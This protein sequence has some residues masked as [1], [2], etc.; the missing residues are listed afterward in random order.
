V[1]RRLVAPLGTIALLIVVVKA[2]LWVG[3]PSLAALRDG[4]ATLDETLGG[5]ATLGAWLLLGWVTLVLVGTALAILPGAVGRAGSRAVSVITPLAARR[6][7]RVALGLAVA[8]GPVALSA[9]PAVASGHGIAGSGPVAT[10][11]VADSP[12]LPLIGRPTRPDQTPQPT[13][14][15]DVASIQDVA[16]DVP[17][18]AGDPSGASV[19][20]TDAAGPGENVTAP[21]GDVTAPSGDVTAPSGDVTAPSGDVTAPSD[22]TSRVTVR[23][24]DTLWAIAARHLG[25]AASDAQIAAE[26][27]RWYEMNRDA[28]GDDPDLILPGTELSP[29]KTP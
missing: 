2:L 7:A 5:V 12:D 22:Q 1:F 14:P 10:D 24:G 21:S 9:G 18:A 29:P 16:S 4:T 6:T 11:V 20:A 27:P 26:W 3:D 23:P 28:I 17:R 19:R 15:L 8:A 25:P 13:A